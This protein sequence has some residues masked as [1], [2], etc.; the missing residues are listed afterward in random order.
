MAHH[1][2]NTIDPGCLGSRASSEITSRLGPHVG[3]G[4][5]LESSLGEKR[6]VN[7]FWSDGSVRLGIITAMWSR[8]E[9]EK[10]FGC[11]SLFLPFVHHHRLVLRRLVNRYSCRILVDSSEGASNRSKV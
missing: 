5:D 8:M 7:R 3:F 11:S 4:C 10:A 1:T 6:L 9:V 2:G